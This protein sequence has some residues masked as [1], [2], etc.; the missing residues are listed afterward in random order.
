MGKR[1]V[2]IATF[3]VILGAL[4]AIAPSTALACSCVP[5]PP[6]QEALAQSEAVFSGKVVSITTE[7]IPGA[8][9]TGLLR[10]RAVVLEVASAWKGV[11]SLQ[12][13]IRTAFDSAGCG[14]DFVEGE[15]YLVYTYKAA[16]GESLETGLCNRTKALADANEDLVALGPGSLPQEQIGMPRAGEISQPALIAAIVALLCLGI[17]TAA[18]RR[19]RRILH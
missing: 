12:I 19:R 17:G 3:F 2:W 16:E 1:F 14:Y 5:P 8:E 4:Q 18:I 10:R 6:P 9:G 11:S 13:T 7:E 15:R